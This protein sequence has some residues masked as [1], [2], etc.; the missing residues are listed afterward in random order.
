MASFIANFQSPR[1]LDE[2]EWFYQNGGFSNLGTLINSSKGVPLG[3][4]SVPRWAKVGDRVFFMCG[5]SSVAHMRHVC[6][7]ARARG[8]GQLLAF[9]ERER[10]LYLRHAGSI[11]AMGRVATEPYVDPDAGPHALKWAPIRDFVYFNRPITSD[12]WKAFV[13]VSRTGSVTRLDEGQAAQIEELAYGENPQVV[14]YEH[15]NA[16]VDSPNPYAVITRFAGTLVQD[17]GVIE[18]IDPPDPDDEPVFRYQM[19]DT[20]RDFDRAFFDSGLIDRD[21]EGTLEKAAVWTQ[22]TDIASLDVS[23]MDAPILLAVLTACVCD[24]F[25]SEGSLFDTAASGLIDRCL[26][27]LAEIDGSHAGPLPARQDSSEV[28]VQ[29]RLPIAI[30]GLSHHARR[31]LQRLGIKYVDELQSLDTESLR[32]IGVADSLLDELLPY[33][34]GDGVSS[35]RKVPE[36]KNVPDGAVSKNDSCAMRFRHV[37]LDALID[38]EEAGT[39]S[40]DPN[41]NPISRVAAALMRDENRDIAVHA[42]DRRQLLNLAHET[43]RLFEDLVG[44]YRSVEGHLSLPVSDLATSEELSEV[45]TKH[46]IVTIGDLCFRGQEGLLK[47][48]GLEAESVRDINGALRSMDGRLGF[49][50]E[51][52]AGDTGVIAVWHAAASLRDEDLSE[53]RLLILD[54]SDIAAISPLAAC[55]FVCDKMGDTGTLQ[56]TITDSLVAS[57]LAD[58][59]WGLTDAELLEAVS[60]VDEGIGVGA[61]RESLTR[62]RANGEAREG[63]GL[64]TACLAEAEDVLGA[65]PSD[66]WTAQ[67]ML[68]LI[69]GKSPSAVCESFC[70]TGDGLSSSISRFLSSGHLSDTRLGFYSHL[71]KC[72]EVDEA[73]ARW[74]LGMRLRDWDAFCRLRAACPRDA[75][76]VRQTREL[77]KDKA[78]PLRVRLDLERQIYRNHVKIGGEYVAATSLEVAL[79]VLKLNTG[80]CEVTE[81][82]LMGLCRNVLSGI[83]RIDLYPKWRDI[84][85]VREQRCVLGGE[86]PY[87]R[88]YDFDEHDVGELVKSLDLADLEGKEVS[89]RLFFSTHAD[90]LAEYD[91]WNAHELHGILETYAKDADRSG[92]EI[93][94]TMG[95]GTLVSIGN[96]DR[97]QQVVQLARELSPVKVTVFTRAYEEVYG[98]EPQETISSHLP[99]I[100]A[101]ISGGVVELGLG[102]L[103]GEQRIRMSELLVEDLYALRSIERV[104]LREFPDGDVGA[105]NSRSIATIGFK[106]IGV[107][108]LRNKWKTPESYFTSLLRESLFFDANTL[109]A[110]IAGSDIFR[111]FM[112]KALR[113][114]MALPYGDGSMICA[115]GLSELGLSDKNLLDFAT[116]A[117]KF[118]QSRGLSYC[119][120][121]SLRREGFEH[122]VL[123][124]EFDDD[125]YNAVLCSEGTRFSTLRCNHKQIAC[126][127][128]AHVSIA[129]VV[130]SLV[131]EGESLEVEELV[132]RVDEALGVGVTRQHVL[133]APSK[134]NLYYCSIANM[135]YKDKETF[136]RE[137][138]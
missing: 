38:R 10:E 7:Q 25:L 118:C 93:P 95:D 81:G 60:S 52:A 63:E 18:R 72:Y 14:R 99:L 80:D 122:E 87:L 9:A 65:F 97:Y 128:D 4:W 15:R 113:R 20:V 130:D 121:Q 106:T 56:R 29:R 64:W 33:L 58:N 30:I 62:L 132:E 84:A 129:A 111:A 102:V 82:E 61:I 85:A 11:L 27:R 70:V 45:L 108:A 90:L 34:V 78:I 66:D 107:F 117:A 116:E 94:F 83:G 137:A 120:A 23:A 8:D 105:L 96:A 138:L 24:N 47:L 13:K 133:S 1:E 57:R 77:L 127:D 76:A 75:G 79:R 31:L 36:T 32:D 124:F 51:G 43:L 109:P 53:V 55:A 123:E 19:S 69:G 35:P 22:D 39:T 104:F 115:A 17:P 42:P 46:G 71:L 68:E 86:G 119:T 49:V 6:K 2:L 125:L 114:R 73:E 101:F 100:G 110:E 112:G 50:F 16:P 126:L 21:Y 37:R 89:C 98:I 3:E 12:V 103:T 74:G 26:F 40:R 136:V 44:L 91:V 67:A 48:P 135:I 134:S 54:S 28:G 131:E 5:A 88:Y 92:E 59:P 41:S